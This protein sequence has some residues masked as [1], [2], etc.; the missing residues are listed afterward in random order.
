MKVDFNKYT[1]WET[2]KLTYLA[3]PGVKFL[4]QSSLPTDMKIYT[5][6]LNDELKNFKFCSL[7][8]G[9]WLPCLLVSPQGL[10]PSP[11]LA[12]SRYCWHATGPGEQAAPGGAAAVLR[13]SPPTLSFWK[14]PFPFSG[15]RKHACFFPPSK[16]S[17]PSLRM[18]ELQVV[19]GWPGWM[20]PASPGDSHPEFSW[21]TRWFDGGRTRGNT[22]KTWGVFSYLFC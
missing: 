10:L 17:L 7:L 14:G 21:V 1:V 19:Q 22:G 9:F 4:K 6:Y 8:P 16:R 3:T 2:G 5:Y 15:V 12:G 20:V 18:Q 11:G 13:P